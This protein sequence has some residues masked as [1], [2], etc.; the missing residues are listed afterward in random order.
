MIDAVLGLAIAA[1][2]RLPQEFAIVRI[3]ISL[4]VVMRMK[5]VWAFVT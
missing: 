5:G 3:N 1:S 2:V 4:E